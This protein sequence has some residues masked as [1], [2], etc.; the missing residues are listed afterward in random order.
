[1]F[2]RMEMPGK[3][4]QGYI[5]L[6]TGYRKHKKDTKFGLGYY[7]STEYKNYYSIDLN[8]SLSKKI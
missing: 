2:I 8:T 3:T 7:Y 4:G 1:M 5:Q 6:L